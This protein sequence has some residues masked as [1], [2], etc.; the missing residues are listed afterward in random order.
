MKNSA[1]EGFEKK[2]ESGKERRLFVRINSL[3]PGSTVVEHQ[4][5]MVKIEGSNPF[6][7]T[8]GQFYKT[9]NYH[10]NFNLTIAEVKIPW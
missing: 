6:I 10:G 1:S 5:Q 7:G 2:I 3:Y 4:S 9:V 8:R